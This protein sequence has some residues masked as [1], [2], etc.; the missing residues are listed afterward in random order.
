VL[1]LA[2]GFGAGGCNESDDGDTSDDV[3][4]DAGADEYAG[5]NYEESADWYM[6]TTDEST[7]ESTGSESTG[8]ESTSGSESSGSESTSGSESSGSESTT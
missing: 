7:S 6:D 4:P 5:P 3:V 2:V 8:D 1:A